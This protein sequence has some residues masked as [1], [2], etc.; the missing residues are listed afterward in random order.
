MRVELPVCDASELAVA[1]EKTEVCRVSGAHFR[2][3][4]AGREFGPSKI[5]SVGFT[6]GSQRLL[7]QFPGIVTSISNQE[8]LTARFSIPLE[9]ESNQTLQPT[10]AAGRG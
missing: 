8:K 4:D 6:L 7:P 10:A 5:A 9:S 2:P 3:V 1:K